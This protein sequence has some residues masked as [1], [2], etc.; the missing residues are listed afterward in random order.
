MKR[1]VALFTQC[2]QIV[3]VKREFDALHSFGRHEGDHMVD[4][5]SLA[6]HALGEALLTQRMIGEIRHSEALPPNVL[7]DFL[8]LFSL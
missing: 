3:V 5:D 4:I 6:S 1:L 8:P 7:V 2:P